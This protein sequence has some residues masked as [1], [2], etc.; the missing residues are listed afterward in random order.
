MPMFNIGFKD[1]NVGLKGKELLRK[2]IVTDIL[3]GM[4]FKKVS[5]MKICICKV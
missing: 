2:E 5:F 4:L 3:V 1:S